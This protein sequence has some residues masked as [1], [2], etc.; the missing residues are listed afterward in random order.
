MVG[1]RTKVS[2]SWGLNQAKGRGLH[3]EI[4]GTFKINLVL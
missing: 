2:L 3:S 4:L 1:A